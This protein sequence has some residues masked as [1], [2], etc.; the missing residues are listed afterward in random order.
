MVYTRVSIM[1]SVNSSL[2]LTNQN[3]LE[4]TNGFQKFKFLGNAK[5]EVFQKENNVIGNLLGKIFDP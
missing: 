1:I 4:I 5:F 2:M 3:S